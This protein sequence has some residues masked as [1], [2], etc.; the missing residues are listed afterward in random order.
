MPPAIFDASVSIVVSPE[1]CCEQ[2]VTFSKKGGIEV[3]GGRS[4][5][6]WLGGGLSLS[7]SQLVQ[8]DMWST[9]MH[10]PPLAAVCMYGLTSLVIIPFRCL[11]Q[12]VYY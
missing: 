11:F 2:L 12:N 1:A 4:W 8:R 7:E 9:Q 3:Q 6:S 5:M 10:N